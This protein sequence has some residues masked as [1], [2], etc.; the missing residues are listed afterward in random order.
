M[1]NKIQTI[2]SKMMKK[3][4]NVAVDRLEGDWIIIGG[5]VLPLLGVDLRG[6]C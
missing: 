4:I 1:K 3:F 2:D 5:T 6:D